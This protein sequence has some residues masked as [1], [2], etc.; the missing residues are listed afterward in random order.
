MKKSVLLILILFLFPCLTLGEDLIKWDEAPM[1]KL[2]K[3]LESI[4]Q[5]PQEDTIAKG[6]VAVGG[7]SGERMIVRFVN[8]VMNIYFT[9]NQVA[10][11]ALQWAKPIARKA[12]DFLLIKTGRYKGTVEFFTQNRIKMFSI[13]GT[14]LNAEL[15][16]YDFYEKK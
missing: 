5:T 12:L 11:T 15:K 7:D 6:Y 2:L 16:S 4:K 8:G 10:T 1:E 3:L 9:D 13:S 14:L